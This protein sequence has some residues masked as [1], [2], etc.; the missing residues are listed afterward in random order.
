MFGGIV[1]WYVNKRG[2]D[3]K[4]DTSAGEQGTLIASGFIA[5]GALMGVVSAGLTFAGYSWLI[6]SGEWMTSTGGQITSLS[7]YA[8]LI[9][10]LVK[11]SLK[12]K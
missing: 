9:I 6:N 10:F 8:L 12:N 2:K 7:V 5:G 1:N 11:Y 4:R 3:K